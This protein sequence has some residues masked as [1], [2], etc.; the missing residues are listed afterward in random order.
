MSAG[1]GDGNPMFL[2]HAV[3]ADQCRGTD[4][5]FRNFALGV[6]ARPPS[7]VGFHGFFLLVGEQNKGEVKF[8]DELIVRIDAIRADTHNHGI[9]FGYGIDSVAEPARFL[10]SARCVVFWIKPQYDV[11]AGVISQRMLF[12]VAPRESE[13]RRLLPFESCHEAPP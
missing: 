7:A 6:L 9:G 13:R 10:G 8:I 11:F 1:V 5:S 4:C 3:G 12:A 2:D